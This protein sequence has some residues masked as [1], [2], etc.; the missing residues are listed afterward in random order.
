MWPLLSVTEHLAPCESCGGGGGRVGE[1][2]GRG[3]GRGEGGGGGGGKREGIIYM[4]PTR[5]SSFL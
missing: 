1:G 2:G 3:R 5:G 4:S